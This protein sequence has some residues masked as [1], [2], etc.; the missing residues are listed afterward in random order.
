MKTEALK[1]LRRKLANK[2]SVYGLWVTLESASITEMAVASGMDWVVI[3]AEHGHLDWSDILDHIRAAVRSNT[4]VLVRI[5]ELQEGLIKRALDIG[6]DGVV[7]PHIE[8]AEE[9]KRA[10]S[11]AN[12]PLDGVR[13]I[14]AERATGWGQCFVEHVREANDSVLVIPIIESLRGGDNIKSLLEVS[15]T[16]IFFFGPADYC[17]S[18]GYAGQWDVPSVNDHINATKNLINK[19]GKYCGIMANGPEDLEQRNNQGFRMV[20]YGSDAG[21]LIKGLRQISAIL[22]R[23]RKITSDLSVNPVA[24]VEAAKGAPPAGFQPD[25]FEKVYKIGEGDSAELAPGIICEALVGKHADA[26]NLFTAIVTFEPGDT[27]L[28]AHTHPHSESITLLNGRACVEVGDRR[29]TL[30]PLDNITVP[31]DCVHSVRNM[32]DDKP[33][34]FHTSMPTAV[35]QRDLV[36]RLNVV[37]KDVPNDFNGHMGPERITRYST[38]RRYPAGP[39]TEFIDFFNDNLMPGIGMSGGYGLFYHGG[40]LPAHLHDFDESICIVEGEATC[41]VEGRQYSMSNLTTAIQPR[42]RVHYF[43]NNSQQPMAMIWVYAGPRPERIEVDDDYATFGAPKISDQ[44]LIELI[45]REVQNFL[46]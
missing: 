46:N 1:T 10:V 9:L 28:P 15:G 2:E 33:A 45:V 14:G 4:V 35:P 11:F 38:A 23:D 43:I 44:K 40:R 18:A 42:G 6:A 3:D 31:R 5:T 19:A 37:F 24:T 27:L 17:A 32:S 25:R 8:T 22:G 26:V 30:N 34:I 39:N 21:L 12:Y 7:I 29:Y 20:A 16:D 36:E 41:F 13:G